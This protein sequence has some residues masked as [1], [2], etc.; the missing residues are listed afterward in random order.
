[1]LLGFIERGETGPEFQRA[2]EHAI[3]AVFGVQQKADDL[4]QFLGS[5]RR[6]E[7]GGLRRPTLDTLRFPIELGQILRAETGRAARQ[8]GFQPGEPTCQRRF[9]FPQ[10]RPTTARLVWILSLRLRI[11]FGLLSFAFALKAPAAGRRIGKGRRNNNQYAS[12]R[13]ITE[14]RCENGSSVVRKGCVA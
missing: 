5:G 14:L 1:M 11:L 4:P 6:I 13:R 7:L 12:N 2:I 8:I 3:D 10:R 9:R